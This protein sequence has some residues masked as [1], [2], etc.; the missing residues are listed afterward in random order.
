[1]I[2][3]GLLIASTGWAIGTS[4]WNS[5][6]EGQDLHQQAL[7]I[8]EQFDDRRDIADTRDLLGVST[9]LQG[10]RSGA[11]THFEEADAIYRELNERQGLASTLATLAHLRSSSRVYDTLS[12]ATHNWE[13]MLRE[14][15]E[16]LA[17]AREIAWRSGEVY[18]LCELA[19]C[20]SAIGEYGR[21]LATAQEGRLIAEEM[22]HKEWLTIAH[23]NLGIIYLDLLLSDAALRHCERAH[24][25]ARETGS[26]HMIGLSAAFLAVHTLQAGE[27]ARAEALLREIV[28]PGA[29]VETL[30]QSVSLAAYGELALRRG[31]PDLALEIADR[32]IAW[33]ERSGGAGVMP[34]LSKLRGEALAALQRAAEAEA[35]LRAAQDE[36]RQQYARP[37]LWRIQLALGALLQAQTRRDEAEQ[38]YTAA[39]STI[40]ELAS[41]LPTEELREQ[42]RS[43]ALA[44][45]PVLRS[46][47]RSR[48]LKTHYGG[49]TA[50][51]REVATLIAR[52]YSN[53]GIAEALV[54]SERT[55]EAHTGHIREK[56]GL[57]LAH[58]GGNMGRRTRPGERSSVARCPQFPTVLPQS[59]DN[60]PVSNRN[61]LAVPISGADNIRARSHAYTCWPRCYCPSSSGILDCSEPDKCQRKQKGGR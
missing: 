34:R 51:E 46:R 54:V 26:R 17:I 1:M 25:L 18:A 5:R 44:S 52:G 57:H 22:E 45:I 55:V 48:A 49:L 7:A 23:C 11:I 13:Q 15:E 36:A 19:A 30:T 50:R 38:A 6:A 35:D 61:R 14:C 9:Y 58:A 60:V 40:D 39:R 47:S 41:T 12:R 21:A 56:L 59:G 8:F 42:F 24:A 29:P 32:L 37:L 43:N 2:P 10:N 53:R 33:A 20:L 4:I 31:E 28:E 3:S 27:P 16:A